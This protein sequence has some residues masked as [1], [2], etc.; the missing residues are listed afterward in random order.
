VPK[1]YMYPL[2]AV[3]VTDGLTLDDWYYSVV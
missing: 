1:F 2:Y 3:S